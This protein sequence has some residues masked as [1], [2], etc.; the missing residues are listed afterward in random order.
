MAIDPVC[1]AEV[2]VRKSGLE[3]KSKVYYFCSDVCRAKFKANPAQYA[4]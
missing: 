1:E 3:Y 2:K 4:K